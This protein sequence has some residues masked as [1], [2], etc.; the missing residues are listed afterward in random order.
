[1]KS[2]VLTLFSSSGGTTE[3]V[4]LARRLSLR[5][6]LAAAFVALA[7]AVAADFAF[8]RSTVVPNAGIVIVRTNLAY[9]DAS[10]AGTGMVLTSSGEVLTNNH[11]IHGA[12]SIKVVVP[13]THRTYTATVA[14]YAV[15]A[16]VAVLRL[17]GASGLATVTLGNSSTLRVGQA[18]RAVG[19]AQGRGVLATATGTITGLRRSIT[20][21]D[22]ESGGERL[23]GLVETNAPLQP[24][25]SGGPLLDSSGRVVG[26]NTAASSSF[27]FR[28]AADAA[29]AIPINKAQTIVRQIDAGRSS[30]TVHIGGTAFLGVSI[31]STVGTGYGY[32]DAAPTGA[33][34]AGVVTGSPADRVGLN[35]G[36][37]ITAVDGRSVATPNEIISRLLRKAPGKTIS[38][39]WIDTFGS[40]HTAAVAL[41]SGPPQ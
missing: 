19:N 32:G 36:D 18:V 41:A 4:N 8:A 13:Q 7:T 14:G 23:T 26:M 20:A 2:A 37:T 27:T 3:D 25:D 17:K 16:D 31:A 28:P 21:S 39:T 6:L 22:G 29:Y 30:A 10:A 1:M 9:Q 35:R 34:I 24:G 11:V 5:T 40:S 38:I 12:T 15:G 33:V